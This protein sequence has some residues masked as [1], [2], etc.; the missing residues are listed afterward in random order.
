MPAAARLAP[1]NGYASGL[2]AVAAEGATSLSG[3]VKTARSCQALATTAASSPHSQVL[4]ERHLRAA[5]LA[6]S[7]SCT[8]LG[9]ALAYCCYRTG[10]SS[11][12][13]NPKDGIGWLNPTWDL[14]LW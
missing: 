10:R 12:A 14:C 6:T 11:A 4:A 2:V 7:M 5:S 1:Q 9:V 3:H 13:V 8:P